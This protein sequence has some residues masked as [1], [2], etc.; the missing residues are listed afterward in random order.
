M[1]FNNLAILQANAAHPATMLNNMVHSSMT[2]NG[3]VNTGT[4]IDS[5]QNDGGMEPVCPP[6]GCHPTAPE[7]NVTIVTTTPYTPNGEQ[8]Y[9][10]VNVPRSSIVLSSLGVCS[11]KVYI[12]KDVSGSA[13]TNNITVTAPGSTIDGQASYILNTDYGSI[14][15]V[16]NGTEWSVV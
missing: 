14:T 13:L 7:V 6:G 1:F 3:V 9:L 10:G 15:L 4:M 8:C 5:S 16:Y 12:I 11:G 2:T